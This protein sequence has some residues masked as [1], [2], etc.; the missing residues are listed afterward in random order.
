MQKLYT[1]TIDGVKAI[2][3]RNQIVII[4]DGFQYVNPSEKMIFADGWEEY[5]LEVEPEIIEKDTL[6]DAINKK[7]ADLAAYDAS[8][9]VN[10]FYYNKY[11]I[12]LDK[13]TRVGLMLRIDAEYINNKLDTSLWYN[14][15]EFPIRTEVAKKM[16]YAIE[17]YAS[18]CYDNTQRHATAI[19]NLKTI[20][21]VENYNFREGYPQRLEF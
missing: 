5:V 14:G 8:D 7:L 13:A 15:Y 4:K 12:W 10:I 11:P 18:E 2:K 9:H 17:V 20:E 1:K 21:E 16:L 3:R 6:E 19:K